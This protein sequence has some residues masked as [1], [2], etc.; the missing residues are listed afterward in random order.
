MIFCQSYCDYSQKWR[1]TT[2]WIRLS[3]KTK[4]KPSMHFFLNEKNGKKGFDAAHN[5][6]LSDVDTLSV[7]SQ[8]RRGQCIMCPVGVTGP[9]VAVKIIELPGHSPG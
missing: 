2:A 4:P 1:G 3:H 6:M 5:L 8:Q 7:V 9:R